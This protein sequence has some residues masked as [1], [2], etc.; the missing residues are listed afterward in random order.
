MKAF[1]F[2]C[3]L[4]NYLGR[5]PAQKLAEKMTLSTKIVAKCRWNSLIFALMTFFL[6]LFY[7]FYFFAFNF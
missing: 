6:F 1:F 3:L 5:G 4:F 7:F 2:F